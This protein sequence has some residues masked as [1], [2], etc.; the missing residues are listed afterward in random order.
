M[1]EAL[2]KGGAFVGALCFVVG[3]LAILSFLLALGGGDVSLRGLIGLL[4]GAGSVVL[5]PR[6]MRRP[7][8]G[9]ARARIVQAATLV[10]VTGSA[11][12]AALAWVNSSLVIIASWQDLLG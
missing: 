4:L 2:R 8:T 7:G 1:P 5:V 11:G 10:A 6:L 12:V 9:A 3:I